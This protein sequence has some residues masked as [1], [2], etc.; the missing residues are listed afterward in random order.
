MAKQSLKERLKAKAADLKSKSGAGSIVFLKADQK[1]RARILNVGEEQEFIMEVTQFYLGSDI[2]GVISP[3]TFG[4]PC[5]LYEQYENLKKSK[6][7]DDVELLKVLSPKKK[8]L[9]YCLLFK[10]PKGKEIDE[11]SPKFVLLTGGMYQEIIDLYLDEDDWGDM[12]SPTDSGYDLKLGRTGS[13]KMDTKYTVTACP[14]TACPKPWNK[15]VINLEEEV[16]KIMPTYEETKE[17]LDKFL[18]SS[19]SDSDDDD[20]DKKKDKKKAVKKPKKQDLD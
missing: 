19:I 2:K 17:L 16:K 13:G 11:N 1:L 9:A 6:D 20:S 7:P 10:D 4:E 3:A 15:K 18:G 5:A 8:Y 12:S 14:K